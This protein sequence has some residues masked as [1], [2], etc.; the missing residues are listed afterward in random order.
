MLK[1][2]P[3]FS[4]FMALIIFLSGCSRSDTAKDKV[5]IL[6]IAL[7]PAV[8]P[9]SPALLA[10]ADS[11]T[12]L[13]VAQLPAGAFYSG[14]F[15]FVIRLGE[16]E[17]LPK[18]AVQLAE[19]QLVII[20]NHGN[21]IESLSPEQIAGLFSGRIDDWQSLGGE[22]EGVAVWVSTPNDGARQ[23]LEIKL[24]LGTPITGNAQL[25]ASPQQMLEAVAEDENAIGFLPAAWADASVRTLET[26]LLLP[27]L[28]LAETEPSI[29]ARAL[30]ACMQGE[31]GQAVL[32]QLYPPLLPSN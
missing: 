23:I 1:K 30:L 26:G 11:Q 8:Q 32:G 3:L 24:L 7:S 2:F 21:F 16:P 17:Q 18:F 29:E 20:L 14:E 22:E 27:L 25:A 31:V 13:H 5:E 15:D 12:K 28:A 6:H 10:C 9:V 19:D 4:L